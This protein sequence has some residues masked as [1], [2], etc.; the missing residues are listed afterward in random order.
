MATI[1]RNSSG[2]WKA[3]IRKKGWPTATKTFRTKKD[4]QD[5]A[6]RAED[7]MVRGVYIDRAPSGRMTLRTAMNRYLNEVAQTKGNSAI[8]REKNRAKIILQALGDYSL[9]AITPQL[10]ADY[11][12]RR[13]TTPSPRT[14]KP[15]SGNTVRLELALLSHLFTVA[16]Q[17]WGIGLT[18]N[19]V[20]LVRKP[21]LPR[22]RDQR[23]TKKEESRLLAVCAKHSNPMLHWIVVLAIETGMR[24]YEI[25]SLKKGQVFLRRRLVHLP[26]TKNGSVRTVPLTKKAA[27]VLEMAVNHS[28]RPSDTDLIFWGDAKDKASGERKPYDFTE[29][30]EEARNRAGLPYLHFHDLRHEAV[31]RLVEVGLGDQE[32]AA[33]SGHKTMQMLKRY[34][35]LRAEDLVEKLDKAFHMREKQNL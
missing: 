2:N 12:D 24:K 20:G 18:H 22:A 3:I 4:A 17:E 27:S 11:R 21:K 6:R 33:I 34:T 13:L 10:I 19:P 23:I 15:L 26:N 9:A 25:V 1:T 29:A 5:W 14:N 16:I 28:V 32:V 31:S 7:E 35:H 30:W 8:S